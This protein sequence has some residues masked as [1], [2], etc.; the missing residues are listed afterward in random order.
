VDLAV[1][2][3]RFAALSATSGRW[4]QQRVRPGVLEAREITGN[5]VLP[6]ELERCVTTGKRALKRLLA[7]SNVS[8]SRMLKE[9]A[10]RYPAPPA[11]IR[12]CTFMH[13]ALT[14]GA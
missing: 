1:A 3:H 6:S 10:T 14:S 2:D 4:R 13:T 11:Q 12:T 9:V 7:T 5:Y 8:Q